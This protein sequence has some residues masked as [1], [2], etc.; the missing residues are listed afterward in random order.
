MLRGDREGVFVS[1]EG[2]NGALCDGYEVGRMAKDNTVVM[3]R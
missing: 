1:V 3:C 2:V